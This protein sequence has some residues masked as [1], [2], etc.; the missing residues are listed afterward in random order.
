V[1]YRA[2]EPADFDAIAR[3]WLE[4]ALAT[5]DAV[6]SLPSLRELRIRVDHEM[7]AGWVV[8]VALDGREI[9][10]FL[11]L[12][13]ALAVPDQIFI[14][15][16]HQGRGVGRDLIEQAK[17]AMPGG[18][19]LRTAS[20]NRRARRFYSGAGLSLLEEGLHPRTGNPVCYYGW[21][22]TSTAAQ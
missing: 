8:T 21:S 5:E 18:F 16:T 7:A 6:S 11:A 19:R 3:V 20:T 4:A 15:P 9:V 2:A 17:Q 12:K 14:L 22:G 10:G 1:K 13:P